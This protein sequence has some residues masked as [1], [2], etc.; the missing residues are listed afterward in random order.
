MRSSLKLLVVPTIA[1]V[2]VAAAVAYASIPGSDGKIHACYHPLADG[3]AGGSLSVIDDSSQDCAD[4]AT[5]VDWVAV[6][7]EWCIW[8]QCILES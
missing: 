4:G 5:G 7:Q 3:Q 2:L 8:K 1:A 6:G